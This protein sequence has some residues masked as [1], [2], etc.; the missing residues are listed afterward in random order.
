MAM[1]QVMDAVSHTLVDTYYTDEANVKISAIPVE[2]NTRFRQ[3]LTS[4]VAGSSTILLPSQ[5]GVRCPVLVLGYDTATLLGQAGK[6][7]LNRG[8]GYNAVQQLSFRIGSS[9]QFFISGQ[10]LLQ[11][12]LRLCKSKETRNALLSLGGNECKDATAFAQK[13]YAYIPLSL[14][15]GFGDSISIPLASDLLSQPVQITVTL[16]PATAFWVQ[17][18][19]PGA[20]TGPASPPSTGFSTAYMQFEQLVVP[21]KSM[22]LANR[23]D[24]ATHSYTMPIAGGFDQQEVVITNLNQNSAVQSVVLSGFRA[25][26]CSEVQLWLKKTN[27]ALNPGRWYKP[28]SVE[29]LYAGVIYASYLDAT[30]QFG[31]LLI[32]QLPT[33]LNNLFLL[34]LLREL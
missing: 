10:Q 32:P 15:C 18:P 7:A 27:D 20:L 8:W 23:V 2:M 33:P 14:W 3:D 29:M 6:F 13:Q 19:N 4:K 17:N 28:A 1:S 9:S 24:M 30:L 31:L 11:K 12:N 21:D 16:N 22:M 26:Q 34:Q 5:N 25:G